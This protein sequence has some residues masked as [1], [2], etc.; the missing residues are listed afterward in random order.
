MTTATA[1]NAINTFISTS[2]VD[3]NHDKA[4]VL[5]SGYDKSND[6]LIK[7]ARATSASALRRPGPIIVLPAAGA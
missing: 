7:I 3:I 5:T 2:Y 6:G 1:I 4:E